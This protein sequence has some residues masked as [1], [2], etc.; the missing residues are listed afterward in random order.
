MRKVFW[1]I[2]A[3]AATLLLI[4]CGESEEPVKLISD[5]GVPIYSIIRPDEAEKDVISEAIRLRADIKELTG[6]ELPI[7]TDYLE[8]KKNEVA[9]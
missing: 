8:A 2:L 4:G 1:L 9:D 6:V 5:D 3:V 7:K